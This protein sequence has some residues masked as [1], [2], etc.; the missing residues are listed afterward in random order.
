MLRWPTWPG[1]RLE[2]LGRVWSGRGRPGDGAAPPGRPDG[3][4]RPRTF[5]IEAALGPLRGREDFRL[6]MMDLA[7][8]AK[9]F[10]RRD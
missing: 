1:V 10:A 2:D 8:P 5:R 7:F 6:L 9:M 4:S 3:L